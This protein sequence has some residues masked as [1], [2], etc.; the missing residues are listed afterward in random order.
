MNFLSFKCDR[1]PCLKSRQ[2]DINDKGEQITKRANK[3]A[4]SAYINKEEEQ[5]YLLLKNLL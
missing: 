2:G 3:A 4:E 5:G 1:A